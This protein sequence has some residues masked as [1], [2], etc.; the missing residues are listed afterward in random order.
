MAYET[1]EIICLQI[2]VDLFFLTFKKRRSNF[3]LKGITV[4]NIHDHQENGD[5]PKQTSQIGESFVYFIVTSS[6]FGGC[7]RFIQFKNYIR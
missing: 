3:H 2:F 5:S 6:I 4:I 1:Q 7:A